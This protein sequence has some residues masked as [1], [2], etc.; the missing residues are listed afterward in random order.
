M[1]ASIIASII[2]AAILIFF[3]VWGFHRGFLRILLTTMAL[4]VT[5]VAAGVL[6]P[7]VSNWMEG[8]F[9]GKSIDK[10]IGTYLEEHIDNPVVNQVDAAQEIVIDKL[11]LPKFMRKDI[12]EKNTASEYASLQ[13][14]SFTQYL[15]T[16]LVNIIL[17]II[18]FVVLLIV[19]YLVIRILLGISKVISRIPV[20]GGVNRILGA[21]LGLAEG[22]LVIWCLCLIVMMLASTPFGMKAVEVINGNGFLKFFYDNNGIILGVNALFKAFL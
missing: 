21:V 4:I 20:I 14:K 11:P 10:K 8:M 16:R 17:N 12:S 5:V 19:I 15:K 22:L 9:I 18:A 7:Y 3:F 13:V 2:V 6:T 1:T